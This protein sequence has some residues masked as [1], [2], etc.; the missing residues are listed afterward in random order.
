MEKVYL[1]P[2]KSAQYPLSLNRDLNPGVYTIVLTINL[3]DDDVF[4][5][6]IDFKKNGLSDFNII[7]IR[8]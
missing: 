5:K 1:P 2:D 3:E 6:E 8:D 4:V 7:E